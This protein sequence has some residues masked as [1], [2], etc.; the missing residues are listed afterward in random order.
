LLGTDIRHGI[1]KKKKKKERKK[2]R[3]ERK[4][5]RKKKK[6]RAGR[7]VAGGDDYAYCYRRAG[8]C[9]CRRFLSTGI[10][11][12]MCSLKNVIS[13]E[14]ISSGCTVVFGGT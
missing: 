12:S 2:R 4:E 7:A 13:I 14:Q 10:G 6:K 9:P 1:K 5:K 8:I 11:W 3:E